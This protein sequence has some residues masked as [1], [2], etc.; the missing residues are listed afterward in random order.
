MVLSAATVSLV[1][2]TMTVLMV[3]AMLYLVWGA[4]DSDIHSPSPGD[5]DRPELDDAEDG[6]SD[7]A[8]SELPDGNAA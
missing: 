6:E 4:L 1:S 2:I 5:D 7:E 8:A 3:A